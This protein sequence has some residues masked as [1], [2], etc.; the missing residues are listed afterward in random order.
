MRVPKDILAY[1]RANKKDKKEGNKDD[2]KA[3]ENDVTGFNFPWA[4][5]ACVMTVFWERLLGILEGKDGWLS[6]TVCKCEH[7]N[8][9][10]Q[11]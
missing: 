2:K 11:S 9:F 1:L 3:D 6:C 7:V 10:L 4:E 8:F 5:D